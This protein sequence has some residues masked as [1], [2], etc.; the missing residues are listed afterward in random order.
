MSIKFGTPIRALR[1]GALAFAVAAG[2]MVLDTAPAM[3]K[4][5]YA[6]KKVQVIIGYRPGGS[7]GTY[8]RLFAR[9]IGANLPG[10]PTIIP[11]NMPGAGSLVASNFLYNVAPKDGTV[12]GVIG[13]S[14]Y[15][16]QQLKRPKINFDAR[17]F[18]WVGRFSDVTS[19]V[20]SWN[21]SKVKSFA[22]AKKHSIPVAVGGTLSGST[23][24]ISF[25]NELMGT[26]FQ[27]IKGY[28]SASAFLAMERTEVDATASVSVTS[29][30]SRAPTWVRDKKVHVLV[31]VAMSPNPDYPNAPGIMSLVKEEKARAMMESIVGPNTVGRSVMAPPGLPAARVA[32]LRTAFDKTVRSKAFLK[33]A[34][35]QRL[36]VRPMSGADLQNYFATTPKLSADL[37][38]RMN[39]IVKAKL[40]SCKKF[41]KD[42][43][44]CR[45]QKKKKKKKKPS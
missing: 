35:K 37:V 11:K 23:L 9:H 39:K 38:T 1:V 7:Y 4:D 26:K 20:I 3:A 17:K 5:F 27:A 25:M 29:L 8:A 41:A 12:L 13:Q 24:Y 33:D 34:K 44:T 45:K 15:L 43:R 28:D 31:Q 14:V 2:G 18:N 42:P 19:L 40:T 10:H 36:A 21:T 16:M 22:D 32:L 6:G 30:K